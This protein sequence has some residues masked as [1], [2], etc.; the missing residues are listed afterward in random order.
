MRDAA[1]QLGQVPVAVTD[2]AVLII[3]KGAD[4][5]KSLEIGEPQRERGIG[6]WNRPKCLCANGFEVLKNPRAC[7]FLDAPRADAVESCSLTD[8][9]RRD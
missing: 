2:C 4:A 7:A 8:R 9:R 1:K 5:G 6:R 3:I